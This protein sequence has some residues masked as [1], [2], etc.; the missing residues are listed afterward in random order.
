LRKRL[1]CKRCVVCGAELAGVTG[2]VYPESGTTRLYAPFCESH[3]A[4]FNEYASPVFENP[5]AYEQF[6]QMFPVTYLQDVKGKPILFFD[7]YKTARYFVENISCS[8]VIF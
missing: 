6:K 7:S 8:L 2:Y 5:A 3:L 4:K 1:N